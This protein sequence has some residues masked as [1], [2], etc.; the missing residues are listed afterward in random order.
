MPL[1]FSEQPILKDFTNK[2]ESISGCYHIKISWDKKVYRIISID[3]N[4]TF[5][6]LHK[7][8][9]AAFGFTGFDSKHLYTF[10]MD[11]QH[12]TITCKSNWSS[13]SEGCFNAEEIKIGVGK[14]VEGREFEY[15]LFYDDSDWTFKLK[16]LSIKTDEKE[17]KKAKVIESVG[18]SPS[19]YGD[20]DGDDFD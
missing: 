5:D 16:V 2:R 10:F 18:E 17:P 9:Y 6:D 8:I 13:I 12:S 3:G 19:Q 11:G 14:L 4:Y 7:A 15:W 1:H 20:E